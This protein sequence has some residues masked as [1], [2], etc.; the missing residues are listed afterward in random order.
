M[1]IEYIR[2]YSNLKMTNAA[3]FLHPMEEY[4]DLELFCLTPFAQMY[5]PEFPFNI[6]VLW[7]KYM[8]LPFYRVRRR[9]KAHPVKFSHWFSICV[10]KWA[11]LRTVLYPCQHFN[12]QCLISPLTRKMLAMNSWYV[13]IPIFHI[14]PNMSWCFWGAVFDHVIVSLLNCHFCGLA[15]DSYPILAA[16]WGEYIHNLK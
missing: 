4:L 8:K 13:S 15:P 5:I 12:I 9:R 1:Y 3:L 2:N 10:D 16:L 11:L 14:L 6:S 7:N